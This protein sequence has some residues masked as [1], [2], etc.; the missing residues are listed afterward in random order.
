M[1]PPHVSS[2]TRFTAPP[3]PDGGPLNGPADFAHGAAPDALLA[4]VRSLARQA[5]SEDWQAHLD[6]LNANQPEI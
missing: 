1:R 6:A 3:S 2:A 5:A 4:F